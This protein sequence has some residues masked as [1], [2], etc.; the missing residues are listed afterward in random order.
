[1][2]KVL[3]ITGPTASGKTKS[4]I[5]L[6]EKLDGEIINCDSL[7]VYN[8]LKTLTAFPSENELSRVPHKL[9]GY[10]NYDERISAVNWAKVAA[11]QIESAFSRGKQ[12]IIAGGTGM[13]LN[14]LV[15]G[16]SPIPDIDASNRDE[17]NKLAS[18]D[19]DS[20][21]SILYELDP[22][23]RISLPKE[24]HRQ[25]IRAYEVFLQTGKSIREFQNQPRIKFIENVDFDITVQNCERD[26]LYQRIE[27]RFEKMLQ[28]GA[29]D[30][31]RSLLEKIGM[32]DRSKLFAEFPIFNAIGAKEITKYLDGELSFEEMKNR[33]IINSKHYAKRQI[34]WFKH[35]IK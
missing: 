7:Q 17:A 13:Y 27:M 18:T 21:C 22:E 5:E 32:S 31:V 15:N 14:V 11:E 10:L 33:A 20:L 2:K 8:E 25:L 24:K 6:A 9:F 4:A 1:M 26:V 16:I 3:V 23:L 30:E 12:P 35:Q 29:I 28:E 34:T 19:F